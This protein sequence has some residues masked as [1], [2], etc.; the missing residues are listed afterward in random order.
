MTEKFDLRTTDEEGTEVKC[1]T[2]RTMA[3][4]PTRRALPDEEEFE[5]LSD[6]E[7]ILRGA[8]RGGLDERAATGVVLPR[9]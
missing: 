4:T 7:G 6:E 1:Q 2:R 9:T 3:Q 8:R 5:P